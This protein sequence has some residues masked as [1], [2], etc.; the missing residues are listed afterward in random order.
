M[1]DYMN[2]NKFIGISH[3]KY[4]PPGGNTFTDRKWLQKGNGIIF[5]STNYISQLFNELRFAPHKYILITHTSDYP[6]DLMRYSQKP[7]C[8]K[9]WYGVNAVFDSPELISIPLGLEANENGFGAQIG[10]GGKHLDWWQE[11]VDRLKNKSKNLER[12]FA[13]FRV[14]YHFNH[15]TWVNPHRKDII[16]ILEKNKTKY[17][18]PTKSY[19]YKE[20]QEI[21][22]DYK[23]HISP[24]GNG[25]DCHRT[26]EL[27][28]MGCIPIVIK[29]KI[30]R[31]W[32]LPIMQINRW[33]DLTNARIARYVDEYKDKEFNIEQAT[34]VYWKNLILTNFK[35]L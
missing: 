18:K 2:A 27:L 4:F 3:F 28:Y 32:D 29:N 19:S 8:I 25:I 34:F 15:G 10:E 26:W 31:D 23:F 16:S 6:I 7:D 14:E 17:F 9:K 21:G 30:Y 22:A 1:L 13:S 12:I 5:S 33:S 35:N 20:F 11:N 24:E